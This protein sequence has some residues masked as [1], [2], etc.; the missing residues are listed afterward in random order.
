MNHF[1]IL[2]EHSKVIVGN[3]TVE[4]E[5]CYQ[6]CTSI[7][8]LVQSCKLYNRNRRQGLVT[9]AKCKIFFCDITKTTKLF[10]EKINALLYAFPDI[11][12]IK[13]EIEKRIRDFEQKKV[14][15]LVHNLSSINARNI[16]SIYNI[17]PQDV[18]SSNWRN[19][20]EFI[21]KEMVNNPDKVA[22]TLLRLSKNNI[23]MKSEF[24]IYRKLEREEKTRLEFK[25]YQLKTII[26]NV[27]HTFF[28]DLS[29]NGI[30][31]NVEDYFGKVKIDYETIQV[32]I[33]HLLD[34]ATK[35]TKSNSTVD[36][37]FNEYQNK[38]NANFI[39][40]SIYVKPEERQSVFNEGISGSIAK[41]MGRNGDGIGMWRIKQMLKL[42]NGEFTANFGDK[43]ETIDG[44]DYAVNSFFL[45]FQKFM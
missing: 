40:T 16:Q 10:R 37:T 1:Y 24:S 35:Y 31:V 6:Q 15:R 25:S 13:N 22:N 2:D 21:R 17:V 34:N 3:L 30:F 42:N 36:I 26:L 18:L 8:C 38:I 39:M 19:Q 45:T 5:V 33:Y 29:N 4:C 11:S 9:N 28:V 23:H 27:L 20:I 7:G 43:L 14:N 32:A 41:E 44:C 12:F